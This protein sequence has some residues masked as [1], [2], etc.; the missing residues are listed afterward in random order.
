MIEMAMIASSIVISDERFRNTPCMTTGNK[1]I[2]SAISKKTYVCRQFSLL[3]LS[4][5]IQFIKEE[6]A[7]LTAKKNVN[8]L[9]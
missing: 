9:M 3:V 5:N 4:K 8:M 1:S 2:D 7:F 6:R